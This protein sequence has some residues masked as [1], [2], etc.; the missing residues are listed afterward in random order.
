MLAIHSFFQSFV[1]CLLFSHVIANEQ[2]IPTIPSICSQVSTFPAGMLSSASKVCSE[3]F[4]IPTETVTVPALHSLAV[5][6]V[7]GATDI[8]PVMTATQAVV[9]TLYTTVTPRI[10]KPLD[11]IF[12]TTSTKIAFETEMLTITVNRAESKVRRADQATAAST[13]SLM[14][15]ES[16]KV[17]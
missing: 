13:L 15:T 1:S 10:T 12:T 6:E 11:G 4:T 7:K 17:S 2:E 16:T 8:V 9:R 3:I 14:L 5:R